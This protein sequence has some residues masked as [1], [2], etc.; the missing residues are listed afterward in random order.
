MSKLFLINLYCLLVQ[1]GTQ[2]N[3]ANDYPIRPTPMR[4]VEVIDA[5][6][7]PR[8]ETNERVTVWYDFQKCEETGRIDNFAKAAGVL[9]GK[10]QG[11]PYDDSDVFKVIEGAA[12]V[13][14]KSHDP[15]LDQYLDELI[16]KIAGAQEEDG[17]LYTARTTNSGHA[18]AGRDRWLNERGAQSPGMDSHEL[19]NVGH[20]YEAAVAH[21][22]ATGKRSLLDVALKNADLVAATWGPGK[23]EIPPGHQEIELGLVKLFRLTGEKK[24][25]DLAKFLLD[26]RGSGK[27]ETP[28]G[29]YDVFYYADHKPVVEQTEAVGHSVRATYMYAAMADIAA[30]T[31]DKTYVQA[32]DALWENVAGRKMYLT[33][34]IGA[35]AST[36]GFG[37][38]Y[39]LP[40]DS[41]NETCAAIGNALW[42]HRMFLLHGDARYMDV[43]ERVI[44][45]GFLAGVGMSGN[46]FFY[47]NPLIAD[48][49]SGFNIGAN[50]RSPWFRCSCCPVNVVR[51]LPQIG[52]MIFASDDNAVYVNLFIGSRANLSVG[53]LNVECQQTTKMPWDGS[54][55]IQI[56]PET[57]GDF[58]VK[59]RIPGWVR[60]EPVA[61]DLYRYAD[62][63]PSKF[64]ILVNGR[65]YE[66]RSQLG[67]LEIHRHWKKGDQIEVRMGMPV[68]RVIA[69][70]KVQS[71]ANSFAVERGPLVYCAEGVDNPSGVPETPFSQTPHFDSDFEGDVVGGV[72]VVTAKSSTGQTLKMIPYYAWCHRGPNEMRVWFKSPQSESTTP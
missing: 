19:Y 65:P 32:I 14:A 22:L 9:E 17:Y 29:H 42:N 35:D 44:Y 21:Y 53:K 20:L 48:G 16:A 72:T 15:K 38:D 55:Q 10:F 46:V 51:F 43:V 5:F 36:E 69:N 24:Y 37:P 4:Q 26:C 12:Y 58:S 50:E 18:R 54:S 45:N 30:L 49:K 25:L 62:A 57:P 70:P 71:T 66:G 41:Y 13:L 3:L 56:S 68:Q 8:L 60:S 67:Y 63:V 61:T 28:P 7:S 11:S 23:L 2:R 59:V 1:E 52:S 34:G 39:A 31:G 40:H 64:Q 33:G 6:W 27:Y 47:P